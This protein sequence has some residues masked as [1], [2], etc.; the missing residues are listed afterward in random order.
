MDYPE[1]M[2]E[3]ETLNRILNGEYRGF[4]RFG[5]GDF[6][7]M[8]GQRDVYQKADPAL[9]YSLGEILAQPQKGVL[10]CLPR[11][12]SERDTAF[13]YRWAAFWEA[14]AGIIG[15]LPVQLYGSSY[16]SRMDSAPEC[17]TPAYWAL[18]AQLWSDKSVTLVRGSDR[19][20]TA[21]RLFESPSPPQ[22]VLEVITPLRDSWG[23]RMEALSRASAAGNEVVLL[24]AGLCSRPL[25]H[26]LVAA[27][28]CA[29]DLGHLGLYFRKGR[30]RPIDECR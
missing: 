2:G 17:H 28:H 23:Y 7:V 24:C 10:N 27:G 14:N 13:Y 21:E 25:V 3:R 6:G 18:A 12:V 30:P 11:P 15:L 1:V 26:D 22:T 8:R 20:L 16:V 9:A 29:Y 4:A 5:D 19:S